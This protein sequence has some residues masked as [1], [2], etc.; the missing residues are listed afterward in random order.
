MRLRT[1]YKTTFLI[2][3]LLLTAMMLP[4]ESI[5]VQLTVTWTDNS[6][7]ED[8]FKIERELSQTGTFAQIA[9]V[10]ANVSSY[11]D[12]GLATETTYCYR[13]RA[14]NGTGDSAYSNEDCLTTGPADLTQVH[15]RWRNDDGGESWWNTS[16]LNRTKI[17]FDNSAS[18][19]DLIDFPVLVSLTSAEIDYAK[20]QG[21]GNDIR[22]VDA[23]GI[24]ELPYEIE[25]WDDLGTSVVWV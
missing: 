22:F 17:T 5:A 15:Y 4:A 25:K 16:W 3:L 6:N 7:N 2:P 13:V 12:P 8:G 1:L 10:G 9:T 11:T 14:F 18:S 19:E 24:T 23:D 20:T 21:V